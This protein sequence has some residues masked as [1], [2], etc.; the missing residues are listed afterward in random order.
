MPIGNDEV[1][2][3]SGYIFSRTNTRSRIG[4]V[5]YTGVKTFNVSDKRE[6]EIIFG[7]RTSG[8][9]L[10][11]TDGVYS[12]DDWSMEV[13]VDTYKQIAEQLSIVQGANGSFGSARFSYTL[14]I[15]PPVGVLNL[16]TLSL[17]V[18]GMKVE[19][20]EFGLADDASA[21]VFKLSGKA[22]YM[23]TTG[24]GVGLAGLTDYL[25]NVNAA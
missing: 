17:S 1:F 18:Y 10:G 4:G 13:L 16:P 20:R 24:E 14:S 8:V 9:P 23:V 7:Q 3:L 25:A 22:L 11:I 19:K 2:R 15:F 6:G 5:A 21:L 12:C